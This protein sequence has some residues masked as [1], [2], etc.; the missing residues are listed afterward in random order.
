MNRSNSLQK[1]IVSVLTVIICCGI[2]TG[3]AYL[4]NAGFS[5]GITADVLL[6]VFCVYYSLSVCVLL[7][8]KPLKTPG[9]PVK[10]LFRLCLSSAVFIYIYLAA[11]VFFIGTG[12]QK[13]GDGAAAVPCPVRLLPL[14]YDIHGYHQTGSIVGHDRT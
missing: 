12:I 5:T 1:I 2:Y 6:V 13:I 7:R 3:G 9:M 11:S 8:K 14:P 4:G 10:K